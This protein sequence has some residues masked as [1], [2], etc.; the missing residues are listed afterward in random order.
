MIFLI[1]TSEGEGGRRSEGEKKGLAARNFQ[2]V[3]L[4]QA[5]QELGGEAWKRSREQCAEKTP[6]L[7][8]SAGEDPAL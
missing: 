5:K 6:G 2:S 1:A 3:F 4:P 7:P 8:L